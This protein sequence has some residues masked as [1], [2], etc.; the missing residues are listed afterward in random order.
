MTEPRDAQRSQG[1]TDPPDGPSRPS[2]GRV[3]PARRSSR[4]RLPPPP[5]VAA[6]AAAEEPGLR[7]LHRRRPRSRGEAG[8]E[9]DRGGQAGRRRDPL[10]LLPPAALHRGQLPHVPGR[11][12]Q[13][14]QAG[15]RLPDAASPRAW[16]IKTT[17]PKVKEQ[18]RAVMEFLLLNHPVDCPICDQAGECKLQDYYMEYDH[19]PLA[20]SDGAARCCKQQAQGARA[21]GGARPG[22]LHHLHP[23]RPLHG[24]GRQG[25]AAGR[26]RPRQPRARS[27]CSRGQRARQRTTRGNTVDVCPVGALL[28]RDFRFK[29]R[30]WFLS[31][32]PVGLHRLLARLQRPTPTSWRQDTYR[33]RPRENEADQQELD[34]RPGPALVQV[35]Q[36]GAR[37]ASAGGPIGRRRR[38]APS[39]R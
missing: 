29:A 20:R 18:Q 38:R 8:H 25:A 32:S 14:A 7:H 21:A 27:T 5:P 16:S 34:V 15:A 6:Q 37:A 23:L 30:A 3:R 22:A 17:T 24:R 12:V 13:R 19:Q 4:A 33:Y 26:V 31:A 28:N 1:A 39:R 35:P 9:H 11:G 2:R 10:L 36:Q